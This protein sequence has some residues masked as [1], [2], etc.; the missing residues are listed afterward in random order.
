MKNKFS[1]SQREITSNLDYLVQMRLIREV[2]KERSITIKTGM[3]LSQE[4]VKYKIF[5]IDINFFQ[6]GT[7]FMK[8][9]T[10]IQVNITNIKGLT[11][12]GDG[13]VVNT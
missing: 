3:E 12:A 11:I 6:S 1:M 10:S 9:N 4:Q 7:L 5:D 2:I 13:S 8:S